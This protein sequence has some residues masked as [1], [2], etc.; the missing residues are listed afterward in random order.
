MR[1]FIA[2]SGQIANPSGSYAAMWEDV[3]TVTQ[4]SKVECREVLKLSHKQKPCERIR[5]A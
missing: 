5:C 3:I 2:Q 4:A 1:H